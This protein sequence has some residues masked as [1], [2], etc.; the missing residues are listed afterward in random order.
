MDKLVYSTTFSL[1]IQEKAESMLLSTKEKKTM[2]FS[3]FWGE[4]Y[5]LFAGFFS[6]F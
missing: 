1:F 3:V 6:L 5:E 2:S 4:F